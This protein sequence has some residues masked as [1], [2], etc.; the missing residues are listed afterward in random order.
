MRL[1]RSSRL[2]PAKPGAGGLDAGRHVPG[3]QG[4]ATTRSSRG[5]VVSP[6]FLWVGLFVSFARFVWRV[7]PFLFEG[8][9]CFPF[10]ASAIGR[11]VGMN[12]GVP[13]KATTS[14]MVY[15]VH[16][17]IS[18]LS[19]S[20]F[21][22]WGGEELLFCV[23]LISLIVCSCFLFG[24]VVGGGW[25]FVFGCFFGRAALFLILQGGTKRTTTILCPNY[26]LCASF[27]GWSLEATWPGSE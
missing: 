20:K 9:L 3:S 27:F 17:L 5:I 18:L 19:T 14:W 23:V 4:A 10:L 16:S 2:P 15:R 21:F 13:L 6:F 26:G 12:L 22:G 25:S 24:G 1:A 7:V 11:N 8:M